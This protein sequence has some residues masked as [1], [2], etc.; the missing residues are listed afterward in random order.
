[1]FGLSCGR[2]V[3]FGAGRQ[4]QAAVGRPILDSVKNDPQQLTIGCLP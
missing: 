1:M 4:R 3:L 2:S